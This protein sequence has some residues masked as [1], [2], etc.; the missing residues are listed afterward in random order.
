M[1]GDAGGGGGGSGAGAGAAARA[2]QDA[3]ESLLARVPVKHF[4]ERE[5]ARCAFERR[6]S[7]FTAQLSS[8]F[9]LLF[10]GFGSKRLLLEGLAETLAQQ[11]SPRE[12]AAVGE[13]DAGRKGATGATAAAGAGAGAVA[14]AGSTPPGAVVVVDGF[15][16]G[17]TV[18]EV[19][20]AV[21]LVLQPRAEVT[22]LSS[23]ETLL[24]LALQG[25]AAGL[26]NR[27]YLVLHN[28]DGPSLRTAEAQEALAALA[29]APHILLAASVD[30]VHA[31]AMWDKDALARFNWLFHNVT[32]FTPYSA[33]TAHIPHAMQER[34]A[35]DASRRAAVVLRGLTPNA[36]A[37]F[38]ALSEM[39]E[40]AVESQGGGEPL[41]P[42]QHELYSACREKF[43][44][45]SEFTLQSHLIEFR[46]HE[47][48]EHYVGD[49]GAERL[50]IPF[51]AEA[52]RNIL[53]LAEEG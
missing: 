17:L 52:V 26:E 43:L 37:V 5:R 33:E 51:P 10:H 28:I 29:A 1:G 41:G 53:R 32:T 48:V 35:E 49:D 4:N 47:L 20:C 34:A 3:Q 45:S 9:N 16:P 44:V 19:L 25:A 40:A 12:A 42:T 6:A 22:P 30:H 36:R 18:R 14:G 21:A 27:V 50:R 13:A 15:N 46:D 7:E 11:S 24:G 31:P 38:A 2:V 8:G 23:V 39:Q